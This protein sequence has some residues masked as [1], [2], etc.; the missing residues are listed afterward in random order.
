MSATSVIKALQA[1]RDPAKAA[2]F[3]KFFKTGKGE[4]GEGDVFMGVAVPQMREV[5]KQCRELPLK[6]INV[7][8][9]NK[10]HEVRMV[11]LFILVSQYQRAKDPKTQ[12]ALVRFYLD[13][14]HA[15]NNWDLVDSTAP[16][17]LGHSLVDQKDRKILYRFAKK[18]HLWTQR[19]A[20]V[21]TQELIRHGQHTDTIK[22]AEHFLS[23]THDL[24]HKA[25][26][27]MLR[28]MGKKDQKSLDQFLKR[29]ASRMPRTMLRYAIEKYP[30]ERRRGYLQWKKDV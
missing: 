9:K 28:E 22:L 16:H 2:F 25:V 30:E 26:G 10:I 6:E 12:K 1:K 20:M 15:V 4:Y 5:A 19:I 11:G 14:L 29:F 21:A 17:I 8:L 27:W 3:P 7:L 18:N 24:M 13:H 23:H